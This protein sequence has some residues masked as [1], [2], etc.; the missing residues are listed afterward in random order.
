M[1]KKYSLIAFILVTILLS[2][3]DIFNT[4]FADIEKAEFY[5]SPQLSQVPADIEEIMIMSWNIKF[6][7]GRIDFFFD[8]WGDEVLMCEDEVLDNMSKIASYINEAQP[9]IVLLQEVD[10]DS[11]RSAYVDQVQFLLD[12]TYLNY[13]VYASQ[14]KADLIPSDGIGRMN[15]GNAILSHWEFDSAE[16]IALPLIGEQDALKQ[17]FYLRRNILSTTLT[18]DNR[19][20]SVLNTHTAAYSNDGTKKEQI[21]I[22]K[23]KL[24]EIESAG[25]LFVGGGDLNAIPPESSNYLG[26]AFPD[27]PADLGKDFELEDYDTTELE[28]LYQTYTPALP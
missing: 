6:G 20:L 22:F 8:G 10:I 15:S 19:E 1:K 7:G 2:S 9:D 27:R 25:K 4:N 28:K 18:I 16:R 5:H 21:D 24:D 3:C 17:Y 26:T 12:N 14:W 23:E 11:K 13:G